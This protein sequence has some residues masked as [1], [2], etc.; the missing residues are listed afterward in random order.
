MSNLSFGALSGSGLLGVLAVGFLVSSAAGPAT[1]G[2]ASV[3]GSL[4]SLVVVATVAIFVY[5]RAR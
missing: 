2:A 1:D 3:F 4:L 5:S